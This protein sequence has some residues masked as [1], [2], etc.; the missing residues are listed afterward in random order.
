[1]MHWGLWNYL[2]ALA[3][4]LELVFAT[5]AFIYTARLLK[6]RAAPMTTEVRSVPQVLRKLRKSEPMSDDE[7]ALAVQVIDARRSP[8]AYSLPAAFFT[9]GCFYVFGSL[10]YLHGAAPSERTFLGV[11]PMITSTNIF[12]RLVGSR[13]L[14]GLLQQHKSAHPMHPSPISENTAHPLRYGDLASSARA[15]ATPS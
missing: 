2:T 1:M 14:N 8:M 9:M 15:L 6:R 10:E 7:L 3:F 12:L 13:R 11:I 4:A 5:C